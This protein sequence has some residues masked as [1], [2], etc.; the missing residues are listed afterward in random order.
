[1]LS[2]L[3]R[4]VAPHWTFVLLTFALTGALYPMLITKGTEGYGAIFAVFA[5]YAPAICGM[6]TLWIYRIP[7]RFAGL[8]PGPWRYWVIGL[9]LSA[10]YL[11][12]SYGLL[13]ALGFGGYDQAGFLAEMREGFGLD[14]AKTGLS[15]LPW[16]GLY[17][18]LNI[19]MSC[20]LSFGEEL[21]WRGVLVPLLAERYRFVTVALLSGIIWGLWHYPMM[22]WGVHD[23]GA[24]VAYQ[25]V[26]FT[27][28]ITAVSFAYAWIR[29]KSGSMWPAL[30]LHASHNALVNDVFIP[31]TTPNEQTM[32]FAGEF[33]AIMPVVCI[34][35][36]LLI[37][38]ALRRAPL[39]AQA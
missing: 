35:V 1:M 39:P 8:R 9:L 14:A 6:L 12:V 33:G 38:W 25:V 17:L 32:W 27:I 19:L 22:L 23:T 16:F 36:A 4:Q 34:G 37:L 7:F 11:L 15:L 29:L 18:I 3:R 5:I 28:T 10:A 20:I 30:M 13:W 24:P 31:L 21:G 2:A 26:M